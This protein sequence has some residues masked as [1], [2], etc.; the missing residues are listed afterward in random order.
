ML[1][2]RPGG[3]SEPALSAAPAVLARRPQPE[4][5]ACQQGP[6]LQPTRGRIWKPAKRSRVGRTQASN[7][8]S[9][10]KLGAA[11]P[12][13]LASLDSAVL[14][15]A[16]HQARLHGS[17]A[18]PRGGA[19]A[20]PRVGRYRGMHGALRAARAGPGAGRRAAAA[21]GTA[22]RR[23]GRTRTRLAPYRCQ[24]WGAARHARGGGTH[25]AR[26]P[27]CPR[28]ARPGL[29]RSAHDACGLGGLPNLTAC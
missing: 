22:R 4:R 1:T 17:A 6:V 28:C 11:R 24:G 10:R 25:T 5:M 21:A 9:P 15:N 16:D 20:L 8:P 7:K 2:G 23:V 26:L 13:V 12:Q 14:A 3:R 27:A 29:R 19:Q 18:R